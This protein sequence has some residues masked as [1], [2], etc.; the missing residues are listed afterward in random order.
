V[1][2]RIVLGR[3]SGLLR[4][5]PGFE[6]TVLG[7]VCELRGACMG[8]PDELAARM[9]LAYVHFTHCLVDITLLIA[10]FGLYP[11]LGLF[12]IPMTGECARSRARVPRQRPCMG[13]WAG[14]PRGA[15][16]DP[17]VHEAPRVRTRGGVRGAVCGSAGERTCRPRCER[18]CRPGVSARAVLGVNA[19]VI[20]LFYRGLLELSKSFL[21]PFGNRRVSNSGLSSDISVDTLL[22]E[23]NAGSLIWPQGAKQLPFTFDAPRDANRATAHG[24]NEGGT[25]PAIASA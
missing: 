13:R 6:Q 22:G 4:G 9:P 8:I 2:A 11:R 15:Y 21:D 24:H 7:K 10:P 1:C 25:P 14:A 12:A 5:G 20:A 16:L 3:E 18:T 17:P 23:S 19:G